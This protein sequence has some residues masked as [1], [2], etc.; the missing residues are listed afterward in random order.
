M[1]KDTVYVRIEH[2]DG[3][4]EGDVG[5]PYY[6]A[7]C[8]DLHFVTDGDTFEALLE[9]VRECLELTLYDGDSVQE[10]GVSSDAKVVLTME[11]PEHA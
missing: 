5:H 1:L 9:N 3:Q 10:Y 4:E 7:S 2:F 8:D 11:L 6:V